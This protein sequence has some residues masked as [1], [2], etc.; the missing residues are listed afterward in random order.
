M[1]SFLHLILYLKNF[2]ILKVWRYQKNT[3]KCLQNIFIVFA[4]EFTHRK[5]KNEIFDVC[6]TVVS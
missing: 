2:E 5:I 6:M 4:Y 1:K 3:K